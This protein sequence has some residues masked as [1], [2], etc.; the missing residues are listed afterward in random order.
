MDKEP[1]LNSAANDI[2]QEVAVNADAPE[3]SELSAPSV[4]APDTP[5]V[6]N[7]L[8]VHIPSR[9]LGI[10][11]IIFTFGI[12]SFPYIFGAGAVIVCIIFAVVFGVIAIIVSRNNNKTHKTLA[13]FVCGVIGL[14]VGALFWILGLVLAF[15]P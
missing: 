2:A 6:P 1:D 8:P 4:P 14:T 7:D 13:G 3:L 10:L 15:L 12:F 9:V 5:P 11:S